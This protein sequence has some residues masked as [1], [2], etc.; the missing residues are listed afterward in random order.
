MLSPRISVLKKN[1]RCDFCFECLSIGSRAVSYGVVDRATRT[2]ERLYFCD[3]HESI[4]EHTNNE[5]LPEFA[6]EYLIEGGFT[7]EFYQRD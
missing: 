4:L 5:D 7:N 6:Q 3:T 2:W 1:Q